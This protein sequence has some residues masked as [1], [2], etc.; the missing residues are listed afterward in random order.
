MTVGFVCI[1]EEN[2]HDFIWLNARIVADHSEQPLGMVF[3]F[4]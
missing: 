3:V 4:C 2:T 1:Y